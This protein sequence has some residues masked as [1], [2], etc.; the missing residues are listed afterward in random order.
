MDPHLTESS[1]R[2][3][4]AIDLNQIPSP[5]E[6]LL[7]PT[8]LVRSYHDNPPLPAGP[9]AVIPAGDSACG[10]CSGGVGVASSDHIVCDG[11]E[12]GFHFV[13][14]GGAVELAEEWLCCECVSGGVSSRRWRL[15]RT[16]EDVGGVRLIDMNVSPPCDGGDAEAVVADFRKLCFHNNAYSG[17]ASSRVLLRSNS[18]SSG[19]RFGPQ[20]ASSI[21]KNIVKLDF[22]DVLPNSWSMGRSYEDVGHGSQLGRIRSSNTA[23]RVPS[24]NPGEVLQ[25]LREFVSERHGMLE[26]GWR[27]EFRQSKKGYETY[28]VYCAP[29]GKIF[30]TM[31]DVASYLGLASSNNAMEP[32]L[33]N[34]DGSALRRNGLHLPKRRKLTKLPTGGE[35]TESK[36]I[37]ASRFS[38]GFSTLLDNEHVPV[39]K[40]KNNPASIETVREEE[41]PDI[42]QFHE[43][44]PLQYED[45]FVLS[46]GK[47]DARASYHDTS[48]ISPVGYR[49]CWHDKVTGSLFLCH[50]LDDGDSGPVYKVKRVSCSALPVPYGTT[51]LQRRSGTES[52]VPHKEKG[53]KSTIS[54]EECCV[55][56][57]LSDPCFPVEGDFWSWL[58]YTPTEVDGQKLN[59]SEFD[60]HSPVGD[61][62]GE[63]TVDGN[64][65]SLVW[66][67]VSQKLVDACSQ[68]YKRSGSLTLFCKHANEGISSFYDI[69]NDKNKDRFSS[70]HKFC[71]LL[72]SLKVL[73]VVKSDDDL[74]ATV[75]ALKHWLDSDRFGLDV[76]FVQELI[77]QC[78]DVKRCSRYESLKR[79]NG[80]LKAP[81]VQNGLLLI[82]GRSIEQCQQN[83][84]IDSLYKKYRNNL[85]LARVIHSRPPGKYFGV[86]LPPYLVGDV[87][88]VWGLV[89]RFGEI[90]RLEPLTFNDLEAELLSPWFENL[91][92]HGSC[93]GGSSG[94]LATDGNGQSLYGEQTSSSSGEIDQPQE[95]RSVEIQTAATK[96]DV[97]AK[98]NLSTKCTA[99]RR[100]HISLLDVLVSELQIKVAAMVDPSIEGE[101]KARRGRR[102]DVDSSILAIRPKLNLLP[103]NELTWPELA[104]RYILAVLSMDGNLDS[105]E[106]GM[107]ECGKVFRCL[108]GDGGVLC[109]SLVG[110]AGIEAD[111]VLLAEATKRIYGCPIIEN[112][113]FTIE[114]DDDPESVSTSRMI[115]G[116][117][118]SIPEWA[119]VLEPV[120]KL[121]TNVGT[122]IRKCVYEAL[123]KDPPDWARTKLER[124]ISKEVYKGN[125]SGPTK[126]AVLSVLADVHSEASQQKIAKERQMKTIVS[127]A[128]VVMRQCRILLRRAASADDEK[129]FCNLLGRNL[130]STENDDEGLLGSPAMVSRPLDFR[131][132]DLRLAVG[133]YNGSPEAFLEDVRELW[134]NISI[135]HSDQPELAQLAETLSKNFE[136]LYQD[137]IV[138]LVD[139]LKEYSKMEQL[140]PEAKKEIFDILASTKDIPK[141]PWDEGV[142]KVCG[143]D[144]DDDS[145]L[146]CDTCDAEY[147]TY[148]LNPPLAR[149][150]DGNWYCPTCVSGFTGTSKA[151]HIIGRRR[152]RYH[153]DGIRNYMDEL[154]RL[155]AIMQQKD[156]WE[157]NVDE[158]ISLLK[159]LCD[160]V[161]NSIVI[162]QHLEQCFETSADLQ[163]KLRTLYS[164]WKSAK[165]RED[166]LATKVAKFAPDIADI[167]RDGSLEGQMGSVGNH[168]ICDELQPS[169]SERCDD[170]SFASGNAP[171]AKATNHFEKNVSCNSQ[172]MQP[173]DSECEVGNTGQVVKEDTSPAENHDCLER[174]SKRQKGLM[175]ESSATNPLLNETSGKDDE[176]LCQGKMHERGELDV[177]ALCKSEG[178]VTASCDLLNGE[179]TEGISCSTSNELQGFR[180]ELKAV[181]KELSV[182]QQSVASAEA[183]LRKSSIRMEYLGTD[184]S[185]RLYW[186]SAQEGQHPLVIVDC[187]MA[188]EP[189]KKG[190]GLGNMMKDCLLSS[191]PT[192]SVSD[193]HPSLGGSTAACPFVYGISCSSPSC[194]QW[195]YYQSEAEVR[196]LVKSL[197]DYDPKER[198][199]KDSIRHSQR[200][201]FHELH[202]SGEQNQVPPEKSRNAKRTEVLN[203]PATKATAVLEC[204]Y[205]PFSLRETM[206]VEKPQKRP[207]GTF[208]DMLY[209][210][211]CLEP[212][213]FSRH[214]CFSCHNTFYT[215]DELREH[216]DGKCLPSSLV[217]GK[218]KANVEPTVIP[219]G[220][221]SDKKQ[222]VVVAAEKTQAHNSAGSKLF[223]VVELQS[224]GLPCPYRLD[225]ISSKFITNNSIREL[226][227]QIGLIGSEGAPSFV[228]STSSYLRDPA[229]MFK[230][231]TASALVQ[232]KTPEKV[233]GQSSRN[234]GKGCATNVDIWGRRSR[235]K[236]ENSE[237]GQPTLGIRHGRKKISP[238]TR[239]SP[240]SM[241]AYCTVPES[242]QKPVSGSAAQILRQLKICLLDMEAALPEGSLRSLKADHYKRRAWHAFVKAA[243]TIFEMVQATIVLEDM[244]K[245]DH[246]KNEWWYWSS[247]SAA[248]QTST[249]SALALRVFALDNAILYNRTAS[250]LTR[251]GSLKSGDDLDQQQQSPSTI[252]SSDKSKQG[253]RSSRRKRDADG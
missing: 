29:N 137:E 88:Q 77:E 207:R 24:L 96:E 158:K 94:G 10:A 178:E 65:S 5:P 219:N 226:V 191:S 177:S 60:N 15:G 64:S 1:T 128:D 8:S 136:S 19:N 39:G 121:P 38:N 249:L 148:C 206:E 52:D 241:D 20:K 196:E 58:L 174:A 215:V 66:S 21:G 185:G 224:K 103:I 181:Q 186:A 4:L 211:K 168:S 140:S 203:L 220:I 3:F 127:I 62:I 160:E 147:H 167:V 166:F 91:Y 157:F 161:L 182:L 70:L 146:L 108:Q 46:L 2:S 35:F 118:G 33:R 73:P 16:T 227:S 36:D 45:F 251:A 92:L 132:I 239:T 173:R 162:R 208:G 55:E 250:D 85:E 243:N 68:I 63:F 47:V 79:R 179:A 190:V 234:A 42:H 153:G 156:Y 59:H 229:L 82:N 12:R 242:S 14:A 151:V 188:L 145:V 195:V 221:K 78:P 231:S 202:Q 222:R 11:C 144:K 76:D 141:A 117:D 130:L 133:V 159:L 218:E 212:V 28:A 93:E 123:E 244:I 150:P 124:S 114:E 169:L 102:K 252:E 113:Q 112:D 210:C 74:R 209:R 199:L 205:G 233:V 110:V 18:M 56:T 142:C 122:R 49:S 248:V 98:I 247:L 6:T 149:I 201:R 152:R 129:M 189:R 30:E 23:F 80:H 25:S 75:D 17:Y 172:V 235:N 7:S 163:Q 67:I 84:V 187:T 57:I 107:R 170:K 44:L 154:A 99:L 34:E 165:L 81:L 216:S 175:Q 143:V 27:V 48:Q 138:A 69:A 183:Q 119:Q 54:D 126:K 111:A 100:A 86:K 72:G 200:L 51:I 104:R 131:T 90:L 139:K 95:S 198:E 213:W 164:E 22:Q 228:P 43:G 253:R 236:H 214:H 238:S 192:W 171:Q 204:K 246:L 184:S 105:A 180:D 225:E 240:M 40:C 245:T 53:D 155:S 41:M 61:E 194:S 32:D 109:G 223:R 89:I 193:G 125:A 230:E 232:I 37:L 176:S 197:N 13:C 217:S 97:D 71:S 87:L 9:A 116:G 134:E 135:A 237:S 115:G 31:S 83:T 101:S 120:K 106:N 26:E 50:V